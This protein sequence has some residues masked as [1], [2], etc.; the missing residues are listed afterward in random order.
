M[1]VARNS[2]GKECLLSCT[3]SHQERSWEVERRTQSY[4]RSFHYLDIFGCLLP[5]IPWHTE[6]K[7]RRYAKFCWR[8]AL[9]LIQSPLNSRNATNGP[10]LSSVSIWTAVCCVRES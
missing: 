7:K 5:V 3:F 6:A 1:H 9:F 8:D 10:S 4:R 2:E